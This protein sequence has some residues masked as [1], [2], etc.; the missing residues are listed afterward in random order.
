MSD[1]LRKIFTSTAALLG[2]LLMAAP[3]PKAKVAPIQTATD[4][5]AFHPR[6]GGT[7]G[8]YFL[9]RK[10]AFRLTFMK[11]DVR[12]GVPQPVRILLF[13]PAREILADLWIPGD[14]NPAQYQRVDLS[15][16]VHAP[17]VYGLMI[18]AP[19]DRYGENFR[20]GFAT[21][22]RKFLVETSRGHRDV[23][24]QEPLVVND[25]EIRG[26]ICF[27]PPKQ[28]FDLVATELDSKCA[29]PT[30]WNDRDDLVATF[31]VRKGKPATCHVPADAARTAPWTIHLPRMQ[32]QIEGDHLTRWNQ[33]SPLP[34]GVLWTYRHSAWFDYVSNRHLL[35][36]Y[37]VRRNII[38]GE[39]AQ[40]AFVMQ[41]HGDQP[42][43]VKLAL[44]Y[45]RGVKPFAK[46]PADE[47]T[48][49]PHCPGKPLI[50][51][52]SSVQKT[53]T[54]RLRVTDGD[55]TTYSAIT[56]GRG[57]ADADYSLET[58]FALKPY[59]HEAHFAAYAPDYPVGQQPYFDLDNTPFV[60]DSAI[61]SLH[62]GK[63]VAGKF[64]VADASHPAFQLDGKSS[65]P[66][67]A[68]DKDNWAYAIVSC[69]DKKHLAYSDDRGRTF[70]LAELPVQGSCDIEVFTGHNLPPGPPPIVVH[71]PQDTGPRT[72]E[73]RWRHV[74]HA[75]LL[76][77]EKDG[78]AIRFREPIRV[79]DCSIGLSFHS[80]C[81]ST[82]ASFQGRTH[83]IW[84]EATDPADKSIPGVPTYVATYDHATG[85][86]S[87][88]AL[89]GHGAPAN[90]IHNTPC[91]TIDRNGF[92]HALVGT[93]GATFQYARSL[94][95]N[96]AVDGWTPAAPVGDQIRQT[97]IGLVCDQDN[98]LHT[99]FRLGGKGAEHPGLPPD[100][101]GHFTQLARQRKAAGD[102][103][104]PKP[105]II[106]YPP[107]ADYS[108]FY[109]R[110]T[111]DRKGA[112]YLSYSYW[113]TY[114]FYRNDGIS[115]RALLKS[116][117]GGQTWAYVAGFD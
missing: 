81:P 99:V 10:G 84:G 53:S 16:Q 44:E 2:L 59:D 114:W 67:I 95:P 89:I 77:P 34:N 105:E 60:M 21:N 112:L 71:Q 18:T 30:L 85:A 37:R 49:P 78:G 24:H 101:P 102:S 62:D 58:P 79:T 113:S 70:R 87:K 32:A 40:V 86:L 117:D 39:T 68:F 11:A 51:T 65:L 116:T 19:E 15:F 106:L 80:G 35:L 55:F 13:T 46:L 54:C 75:Y 104:W 115:S 9:A 69:R 43:T 52:C 111:I 76:I 108:V 31:Q 22:C 98:L 14:G 56:V 64:L 27:H 63:W 66:K 41:N 12:P 82:I 25:P 88:P 1:L 97:Y 3:S 96:S 93:H 8:V 7:G 103:Q 50:V 42:K 91:L 38:P 90:D 45:D 6:I 5:T 28:A 29:A 109:H 47:V 72:W 57:P 61:R 48:L 33:A 17:G 110:L 36:P 100:Q 73:T 20:W 23:R 26:D 4:F 107:F 83:L 94:Q 92:L 74:N